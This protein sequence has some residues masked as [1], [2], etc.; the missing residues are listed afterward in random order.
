MELRRHRFLRG[1]SLFSLALMALGILLSACSG[2]NG[3]PSLRDLLK[4][5]PGRLTF[6]YFYTPG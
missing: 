1:I 6:V 4:L 2:N 3:K 5:K